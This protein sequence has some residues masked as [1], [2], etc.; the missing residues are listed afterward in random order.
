[1]V[2]THQTLQNKYKELAIAKAHNLKL[3]TNNKHLVT[4][5]VEIEKII[6]KVEILQHEYNELN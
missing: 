1:L 3:Q 6:R 2:N 5:I 4:K